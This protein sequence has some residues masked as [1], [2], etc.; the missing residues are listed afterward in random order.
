MAR[1]LNKL[2]DLK[3]KNEA[4]M[5]RLSDGGGLYLE[6]APSG[7]K[8]WL[9]M[10]KRRGKRTAVGLGGYPSTTLAMVREKADG[11]RKT[12]AADG[13]PLA[14]AR[15]EAEPTFGEAAELFL[16]DNEVA[17]RN[18]KHRA[19]WRMTLLGPA[20]QKGERRQVEDYCRPL[21]NLKV[22]AITTA[23]VLNVLRPIWQSKPETASR[24][25]GRIE[26]VLTFA[27]GRGWRA[28]ENPAQWRGHLQGILPPPKKLGA[29]GHHRAMKFDEVPAFFAELRQRQ[30]IS[31]L[32]LQFIILTAARSGEAL[33]A[34]WEEMDLN[35]AV[36]TVPAK[37]MKAGREHAVPL[38]EPAIEILRTLAETRQ[39]DFVFCGERAG[40]PLSQKSLDN[41]LARMKVKKA[42][43]IHGFRSAFRDWAGDATN[44]PR[45]IAEAALAHRVGDATELA[46]RR[47]NALQKRRELMKAWADY[48]N[49]EAGGNVVKLPT[50]RTA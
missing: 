2:S 16:A 33:G 38:A 42:T 14:E 32:A 28:G 9:F 11:C 50:A 19:Q 27:K 6:I 29:R 21:R 23:D 45:E 13:D 48:L 40:K 18:A 4:R 47:S 17:W 24:L 20:E 12:L 49:G 41:L 31:A 46:Y 35:T 3:V 39:N 7:S 15:R 37:R 44:F 22:S 30:A 5:G 8:S 43:T 1:P 34:R 25:R 10:F 26:R 36:W